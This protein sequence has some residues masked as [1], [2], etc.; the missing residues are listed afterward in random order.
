MQS[1]ALLANF[2]TKGR[3]TNWIDHILP[4]NCLLKQVIEERG[5]EHEA[6]VSSYLMTLRKRKDTGI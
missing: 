3:K 4:R 1:F 5:S 2:I 6:D